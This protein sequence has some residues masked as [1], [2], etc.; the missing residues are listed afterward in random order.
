MITGAPELEY[1]D[2]IDTY[3]DPTSEQVIVD[4]RYVHHE[5]VGIT[6]L[7]LASA[8]IFVLAYRERW[9]GAS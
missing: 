1:G 4:V 9:S 3:P 5:P 6:D 7:L 2:A 8:L